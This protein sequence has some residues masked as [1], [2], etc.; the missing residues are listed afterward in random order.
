[1][2]VQIIIVEDSEFFGKLVKRQ[3]I[4]S[5][6]LQVIWYK[7]YAE[8]EAGISQLTGN[9]IALLDFHLPDAMSGEIIDLFMKKNIPSIVMTGTFSADLQELIWSK[10]VIDYVIKEGG[11]SVGY[12][13]ELIDRFIK[14]AEIG[15]LV[16]DDSKV[17]REHLKKLLGIHQ[18]KVYEAKHGLEGIEVLESHSDIKLVLVDYEMPVCDG[19][20]FTRKVRLNYS[21][22]KL[23]IIGIS[24]RGSHAMLTKFVKYGANDF[25]TKP[26]ISE[27]LYCRIN[28]NLKIIDFFETVKQVA[29]IDHLTKIH[30]RRYLFETGEVLFNSA[31]RNGTYLTATMIDIDNFKNVNDTMGHETGDL[32][33]K[34]IANILK[35]NIRNSDILCRYGGE[36]FCIIS[37]N[38][39]PKEAITLFDKIREKIFTYPFSFNNKEFRISASF[40]VCIEKKNSLI[41]MINAADE[42]LYDAKKQGKNRICV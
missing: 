32:V 25:I 40:G 4:S 10:K 1:M 23:A 22:D 13:I 26:F 24:A 19:F 39:D 38:M 34:K 30:N 31:K 9:S 11:H 37:N 35:D 33:I 21:V 29:L 27:L 16:V 15:I 6:G 5:L 12:I 14:N 3:I 36:E 18:F 28:Q 8:A 20:E 7:S 2:D 41:D 42:K 17:G